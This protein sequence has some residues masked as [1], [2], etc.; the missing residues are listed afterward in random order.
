[1]VSGLGYA[2]FLLKII[3]ILLTIETYPGIMIFAVLIMDGS[4]CGYGGTG[5][6]VRFRF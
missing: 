5:R 3:E 1:M 4:I 2:N 6:R